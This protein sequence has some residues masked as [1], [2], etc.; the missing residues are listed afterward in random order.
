MAFAGYLLLGF[1]FAI[2]LRIAYGSINLPY[3]W[4]RWAC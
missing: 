1:I 2:I 3:A 4:A